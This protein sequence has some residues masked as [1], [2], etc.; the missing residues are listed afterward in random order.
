[1]LLQKLERNMASIDN[2]NEVRQ[3]IE[4]LIIP[5]IKSYI[6]PPTDIKN[7]DEEVKH[8][9]HIQEISKNSVLISASLPKLDDFIYE[10]CQRLGL[11]R[12]LVRAYVFPAKE[13]SAF[14]ISNKLPITIALSAGAIQSLSTDELY[15]V[16]GHEIGHALIGN[17]IKF[18]DQAN[19]LED[20]IFARGV[21][22]SADRIGLLATKNVESAKNAILKLLTGLD[23]KYLKG[24][25]INKILDENVAEI[26][27]E[28]MYSSHPPL[29]IR[30]FALNQFSISKL[31]HKLIDSKGGSDITIDTI[32]AMTTTY[33]SDS[34]DKLAH[35]KISEAFENFI[36]WPITLLIFNQ[37]KI[38]IG[39]MS[40]K[41]D[42][43]VSKEDIQK[44]FNYINSY[45]GI[46]KSEVF[47][48]KL[49]FSLKN[50]NLI[51]PRK[52][53]EFNANFQKL[54]PTVQYTKMDYLRSILN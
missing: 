2:Y 12:S 41:F 9:P 6:E 21:E 13:I 50:L 39:D 18:N 10:A 23:D 31:F 4:P 53:S 5:F 43:S 47:Y 11:D 36:L 14:S 52:L 49:I 34:V 40:K 44:A 29:L 24:S 28:D 38:D 3:K 15:F 46:E 7:L 1:M 16:I 30:I 45:S 32:N 19:T 26:V 25:N 22:I 42:S 20:M 51:A 54:F 37:I 35:K 27:E 17:L 48:E 33:L 8:D